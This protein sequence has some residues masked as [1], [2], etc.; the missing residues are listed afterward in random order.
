MILRDLLPQTVP[1][2]IQGNVEMEISQLVYDSRLAKPGA[3]FFALPGTK[4]DGARF[5]DHA[6]ERGARAVVA[7]LV[8]VVT[9]ELTTIFYDN[10]RLLLGLMADRFYQSPSTRLTLIGVTG[11]SGKTTTTYLLEA[12]WQAVGW[13]TGVI[14]T[15]N[16]RYQGR[17]FP[18]PFTTP[19]AVELQDLLSTMAAQ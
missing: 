8:T 17:E 4:N 18:A 5:I 11:T 2:Q 15:V 7:S 12:I 9:G 19:E 3:L 16:Y 10:P 6:R 1:V 13:S 14:G